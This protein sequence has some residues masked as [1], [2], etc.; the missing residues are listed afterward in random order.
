MEKLRD[1]ISKGYNGYLKVIEHL[2]QKIHGT[3]ELSEQERLPILSRTML[4]QT[5]TFDPL[6]WIFYCP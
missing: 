2:V 3:P 1:V 6:T 5:F 4:W